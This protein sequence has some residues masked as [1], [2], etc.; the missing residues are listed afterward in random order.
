M[1]AAGENGAVPQAGARAPVEEYKMCGVAVQKSPEGEAVVLAMQDK[2]GV[3]IVE[4]ASFYDIRAPERMVIGYEEVSDVFGEDVDGFDIQVQ[5]STIYGRIVMTDEALV[6][7]S[8]F[9]EAA[10]FMAA[11]GLGEA[12]S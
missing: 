6:L 2:P 5:F 7:F 1:T 8:D 3:E 11:E 12:S 9:K 4:E 10:D